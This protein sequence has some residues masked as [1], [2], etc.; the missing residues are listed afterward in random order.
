[1]P[2]DVFQVLVV[3]LLL[4][5]KLTEAT[6]HMLYHAHCV[7]VKSKSQ[8]ILYRVIEVRK[9]VLQRKSL[10]NL[11]DEVRGVVVAAEVKILGSYLKKNQ[12]IFF[13]KLEF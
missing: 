13:R 3:L 7:F 12:M 1:M 6:D 2:T 10:D 9:S 11:L 4:A 5:L 8:Q